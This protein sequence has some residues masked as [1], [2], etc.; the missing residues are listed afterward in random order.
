MRDTRAGFSLIEL[1]IATTMLVG[2]AGAGYALFRSQ[3]K[4]FRENT[5]RYDLVQNAR[6]S[7]EWSDRVIRTMGAGVV[8][9]QPM[10]VYGA[11]SVI[12]FNADFVERD[13][14]DVRWAAYWNPDVPTSDAIVWDA[15]Q[16]T[17][18]PNSSPSYAYPS[19]QYRMSNGALSPAETYILYFELDAATSRSDDYI[20]YQRVNAGTPEI[21]GRN[22]LAAS[23]GAPFFQFLLERVLA[24]GD[25]LITASGSLLPL[26]RREVVAGISSADSAN[27]VRPDS[28][29]AVRMNYRIT[30]GQSGTA[31][32]VREVSTVIET[33][34]NGIAMPTVCGRSP[35][36][37]G[38][39]AATEVGVGEGQVQLTWSSSADQD[40]GEIDVRQYV[41]WR[42][43]AAAAVWAEPLLVVRTETGQANYTSLVTDNVPGTSY[44]YAVAAQDCTP[45]LSTMVTADI[46]L[47]AAG[48][49]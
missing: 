31:E 14:T 49:P 45:N 30:N 26:I 47:S 34:N 37:P 7:M 29:R 20:L 25:T 48:G 27:Y 10:L 1:L 44:R 36:P 6:G 28:V 40:G 9:Q 22:I 24:T 11:N 42:R 17:A 43:L 39:L 41:V 13:T 5:E 38:A 18:I 16:A 46:T 2:L 3:S 23:S 21:L 4:S 8:G 33:P 35:L 19:T 15:A 32:R 12:A